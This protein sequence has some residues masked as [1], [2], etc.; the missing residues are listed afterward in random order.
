[1][2]Y[3]RGNG[4]SRVTVAEKLVDTRN[5]NGEEHS[6]RPST[7]SHDG[8]GRVINV[9]NSSADFGI[10]GIFLELFLELDFG[11]VITI[12]NGGL[13][14]VDFGGFHVRIVESVIQEIGF[15]V[16]DNIGK[17][18]ETGAMLLLFGGVLWLRAILARRP[19]DV[20]IGRH[21]G[22]RATR[23]GVQRRKQ[24]DDTSWEKK[25]GGRTEEAKIYVLVTGDRRK[26]KP[27]ASWQYL[28]C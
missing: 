11:L 12:F 6:E 14:S 24:T 15:E 13:D 10:G 3:E 19:Y 7:E 16:L 22:S 23:R 18:R 4:D 5:Q 2:G 20:N 28:V 27:T 17:H 26:S 8:H 25:R 21:R 9:G 1:L